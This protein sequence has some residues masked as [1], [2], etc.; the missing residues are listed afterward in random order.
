MGI[1]S[2]T[3]EAVV[4]DVRRLSIFFSYQPFLYRIFIEFFTLY[5]AVY[6]LVEAQKFKLFNLYYFMFKRFFGHILLQVFTVSTH[7]NYLYFPE[8]ST[9]LQFRWSIWCV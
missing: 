4:V 7:F 1:I 2:T 6:I 3:N 8:R 5:F 9:F